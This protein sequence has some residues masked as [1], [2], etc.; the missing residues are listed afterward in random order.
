MRRRRATLLAAGVIAAALA[1]P[2]GALAH[3][4]QH[5]PTDGHLLGTGAFGK[6]EL[7]GQVQV[8]DAFDDAVADVAVDPDGDF[9]YLANWGAQDCAGPETGGQT[10]PDA[11]IYVIDISDLENPVEVGFIPMHQDTRPGEGMHVVHVTTPSFTGDILAVNEEGCG[12]N[13]KAGFSL[14]DVTDPLNPIKLA[15]NFGDRTVDGVKT[16]GGDANQTHS[17]FV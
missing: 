12:K 3:P 8:H 17:V 11:G 1:I 5:G 6:V 9:A 14:W 4:G 16:K 2:G 10:T 15:K 13:F 7:V